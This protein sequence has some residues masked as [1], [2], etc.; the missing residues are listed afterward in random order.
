MDKQKYNHRKWK[1]IMDTTQSNY[2][3]MINRLTKKSKISNFILI[4]YS[5][6][7]IMCS[8]T[9]KFFPVYFNTILAEYFNI[10]I[11]IIM[12]AYSIINS[13]A[14][15]TTRITKIEKSLNEIKT[16]K[17]ELDESNLDESV[18]KYYK[19]T[20]KTERREDVDFFITVKHLCKE[21]NINWKTNKRK[22]NEDNNETKN[23]NEQEKKE[24]KEQEDAVN[25]YLSEINPF[26]QQIKIIIDFVWNMALLFIPVILFAIC[27]FI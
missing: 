4:Y 20:D 19:I 10:L 11:S 6:F 2:A 15:Y 9:S 23:M 3:C 13:N 8:L 17:R 5:I 27:F 18:E 12:L 7:L 21:Y 25:N 14:D 16:L 22:P 1:K 24:Y 26:I